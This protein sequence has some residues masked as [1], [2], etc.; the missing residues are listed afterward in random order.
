[1]IRIRRKE[2]K[3]EGD[4]MATIFDPIVPIILEIYY[5]MDN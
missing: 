2:T 1:M 5:N 4:G 3:G